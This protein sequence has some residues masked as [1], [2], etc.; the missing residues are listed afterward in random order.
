VEARRWRR[1]A[2]CERHAVR[3]WAVP[4]QLHILARVRVRVRVRVRFRVRVRV[5]ARVRVRVR[6]GG[7]VGSQGWG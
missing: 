3:L 5:R 1:H 6:V 7:R 4:Q 2:W